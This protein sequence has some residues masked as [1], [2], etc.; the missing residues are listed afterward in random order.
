MY[1][2]PTIVRVTKLMRMKL[3][4]YTAHERNEE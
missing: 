2:S 3:A 1:S 4:G